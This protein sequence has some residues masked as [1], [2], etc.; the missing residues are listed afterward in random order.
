V[1]NKNA[2]EETEKTVSVQGIND[3]VVQSMKEQFYTVYNAHYERA[4]LGGT[5]LIIWSKYNE[6]VEL[7]L[8]YLSTTVEK[9]TTC[10]KCHGY[11]CPSK[12]CRMQP[13]VS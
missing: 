11:V 1:E 5:S 10:T 6:T 2:N 7:L 13:V 3:A 12:N 8:Q 4:V 9:N